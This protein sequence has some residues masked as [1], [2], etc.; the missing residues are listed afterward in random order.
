[1]EFLLLCVFENFVV[2]CKRARV[3]LFLLSGSLR[4]AFQPFVVDSTGHRV[5]V[6]MLLIFRTLLQVPNKH[7]QVLQNNENNINFH[8]S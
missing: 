5:I 1:M 7:K 6:A 2:L 3:F 8:A 4:F